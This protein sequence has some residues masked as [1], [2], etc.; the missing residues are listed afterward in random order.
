MICFFVPGE[1]PLVGSNTGNVITTFGTEI[2]TTKQT[3]YD[4]GQLVE[5]MEVLYMPT[6]SLQILDV[7]PKPEPKV[8]KVCSVFIY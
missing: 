7:I 5:E 2:G 4:V 3:L 6:H 1:Y 8:S